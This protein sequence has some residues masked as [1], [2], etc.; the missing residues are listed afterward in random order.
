MLLTVRDLKKILESLNDQDIVVLSRDS[1]GNGYSTLGGFSSGEYAPKNHAY[2]GLNE[3]T[4]MDDDD[5]Y[6]DEGLRFIQT[7]P[8]SWPQR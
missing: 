2:R 8:R 7:G 6:S 3:D 4:D 1:E 5:D